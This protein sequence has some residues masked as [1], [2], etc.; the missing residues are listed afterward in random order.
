MSIEYQTAFGKESE[1]SYDNLLKR[2][3]IEREFVDINTQYMKDIK[4]AY[5]YGNNHGQEVNNQYMMLG[6]ICES[7]FNTIHMHRAITMN[8][9]KVRE[10][11]ELISAFSTAGASDEDWQMY[12][13]KVIQKMGEWK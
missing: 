1:W 9:D 12:R 13:D 3:G 7:F 6:K 10:A 8:V 4:E 2:I 11:L 5:R